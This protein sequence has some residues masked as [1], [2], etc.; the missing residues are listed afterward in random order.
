[1]SKMKRF[2]EEVSDVLGYGGD[3]NDR[4][5]RVAYHVLEDIELEAEDCKSSNPEFVKAVKQAE[6]EEKELWDACEEFTKVLEKHPVRVHE[7]LL[8]NAED[9]LERLREMNAPPTILNNGI[10][11]VERHRK[12]LDEVR[13]E[14]SDV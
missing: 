1:M 3:I 10:A 12:K 6:K 8:K 4:C 13:K 9:S 5:S 11:C 2:L 7:Y 14:N